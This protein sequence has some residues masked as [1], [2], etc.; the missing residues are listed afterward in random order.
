MKKLFVIAIVMATLSSCIKEEEV[1]VNVPEKEGLLV[2]VSFTGDHASSL[3]SS[4]NTV[5][6][7][8]WEKE[9]K[10]ITVLAF[11]EDG[12][13][14]LQQVFTPAELAARTA[15][16]R[17]PFA[18]SGDLIKFHAVANIA[19]PE[20]ISDL[21]ELEELM[22]IRLSL[23][24][25]YRYEYVSKQCM[26]SEGFGM[27]GYAEKIMAQEGQKTIVE[28]SLKR[29]VAKIRVKINVTE[30]FHRRYKGYISMWGTDIINSSTLT[31][32]VEKD[33]PLDVGRTVA[34]YIY[35][36]YYKVETDS[37]INLFY[38][39]ENGKRTE[40][41]GVKL[42][43][44]GTYNEAGLVVNALLQTYIVELDLDPLGEG[45]VRRNCCYDVEVNINDLE[46]K[47]LQYKILAAKWEMPFDN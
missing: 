45:I 38:I 21:G 27:T 47:N 40:G 5:P 22:H 8:V 6:A 19:L 29:L 15:T 17:L 9:L 16:Y 3:K 46:N 25:S 36:D 44:R 23:Y 43:I 13:C 20:N 24:N 41:D 26:Y 35:Q 4:M 12:T 10:R 30:E 32:I 42:R 18:A 14:I 34:G 1:I 39:Y 2:T 37:Y 33:E 11:K 7:E 28:I 31:R